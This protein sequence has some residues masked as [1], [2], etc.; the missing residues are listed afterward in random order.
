MKTISTYHDIQ[1]RITQKA[2]YDILI[3]IVMTV[4]LGWYSWFSCD[5]THF[6]RTHFGHY[7]T[8]TYYD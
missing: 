2:H 6:G 5:I 1:L 8:P 3:S 4:I 7:T